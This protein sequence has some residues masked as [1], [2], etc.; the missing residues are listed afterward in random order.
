MTVNRKLQI[1]FIIITMIAVATIVI[2]VFCVVTFENYEMT[3]KQLDALLDFISEN[4][5]FMPE[6]KDEGYEYLAEAA[7]YSTRFFTI[8]IDVNGNIK[9]INL[10]N[11]ASVS[12]EE[13]RNITNEVLRNS[14]NIGFFHNLANSILK[15]R[16]VYGFFSKYKYKITNINREKLIVFVDCQMQLQSFKIAT[17]K[18][19]SVTGLALIVIFI[20]LIIASKKILN[21]V[22]K[23]IEK[24]K[25]FITNASHEIKTPLSVIKADIDILELT[26]G[27][28]NEWLN[29]IKNQTNRLDTLTKTLLTLANIQDGKASLET[30]KFSINELI[31]GVLEERKLL[32][33]D[34]KIIFNKTT[35]VFAIADKNMINQLINILFDN[36]IK[37]TQKD[38]EIE[39]IT[40][41][42]GKFAKI[43]IANT[44]E[45]VKEIDTRRLFD[46]F[47]REDK[48]R[49]EKEGYGIGLS[50]AQSIVGIHKGKI[51]AGLRKNGMIYFRIII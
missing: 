13:A 46:R 31:D 49:S 42:K 10:D 39:I 37:Y 24:Q 44:C 28:N 16:K 19:L 20:A 15:N 11:I 25:N 36:A 47:Y 41:K 26:V 29:S 32:I 33:E 38:G 7:R 1:K 22:F 4:D 5:G 45:N 43:E 3:N 8:R 34:R 50:I 6:F 27:E 17:L 35:D 30:S 21:P 23:S 51:N 2:G 40:Q 18:S 9:E 14:K 48:S 12:H